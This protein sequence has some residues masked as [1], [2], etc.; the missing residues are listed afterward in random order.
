MAI[1]KVP[2]K[3]WPWDVLLTW[4]CQG[5]SVKNEVAWIHFPAQ[6]HQ[7]CLKFTPAHGQINHCDW[8]MQQ[9][10]RKNFIL[11]FPKVRF[12]FPKTSQALSLENELNAERGN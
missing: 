10:K 1:L 2:D 7:P 11:M 4:G 5:S 8:V 3:E 9:L 12:H 6:K